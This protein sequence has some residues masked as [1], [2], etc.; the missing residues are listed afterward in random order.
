MDSQINLASSCNAELLVHTVSL[1]H[2][3][4][5]V[6]GIVYVKYIAQFLPSLNSS[7]SPHVDSCV[8]VPSTAAWAAIYTS[9]DNSFNGIS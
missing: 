5:A 1:T 4:V 8:V 3:V 2:D 9:P 6:G 7:P